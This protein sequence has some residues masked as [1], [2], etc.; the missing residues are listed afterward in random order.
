VRPLR[1]EGRPGQ[2][3]LDNGQAPPAG[4]TSAG[5]AP[6]AA[7]A[8]R[9][10]WFPVYTGDWL[11]ETRGWP[12]VARAVYHELL[13]AQWDL[14]ILPGET[15]RLR[16]LVGA[17]PREWRVAWPFVIEKFSCVPGGRQNLRLE[18]YRQEALTLRDRRK[19]ASQR[20]H[21]ARWRGRRATT[22]AVDA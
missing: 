8:T 15:A 7:S 5:G 16:A 2:G 9:L 4:S 11:A 19:A 14:G 12:L 1:R 6:A 13:S 21:A 17:T 20:A 22:G 18:T 3:G 10:A